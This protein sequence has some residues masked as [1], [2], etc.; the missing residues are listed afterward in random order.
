MKASHPDT[1]ALAE[2]LRRAIARRRD[3]LVGAQRRNY[4]PARAAL[5]E[6][7]GEDYRAVLDMALRAED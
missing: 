3:R 5:I 2:Q 4:S 6:R 1:H 7:L